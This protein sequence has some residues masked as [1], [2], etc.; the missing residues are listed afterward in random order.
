M[1]LRLTEHHLIV[2]YRKGARQIPLIGLSISADW[3]DVADVGVRVAIRGNGQ[4]IDRQQPYSYG[5]SGEAQ[6][7]AT[8]FTRLT[9]AVQPRAPGLLRAG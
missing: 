9:S 1:G 4:A 5:A 8:M 6:I 3:A 2:G 7:F